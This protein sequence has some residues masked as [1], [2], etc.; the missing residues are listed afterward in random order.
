[1]QVRGYF[2]IQVRDRRHPYAHFGSSA[3]PTHQDRCRTVRVHPQCDIGIFVSY[4]P[5]QR[6]DVHTGA[7]RDGRAVVAEVVRA[8]LLDLGR[9]DCSRSSDLFLAESTGSGLI[10]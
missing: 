7:D 6:R 5:R 9:L 10:C 1:M 8:D 3:V 4:R 2:F